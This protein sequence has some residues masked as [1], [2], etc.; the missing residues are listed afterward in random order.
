MKVTKVGFIAEVQSSPMLWTERKATFGAADMLRVLRCRDH[1][2]NEIITFEFPNTQSKQCL[3][4][5][6]VKWNNFC[7]ETRTVRYRNIQKGLKRLQEIIVDQGKRLLKL[8]DIFFYTSTPKKKNLSYNFTI[9]TRIELIL[10]KGKG[11]YSRLNITYM[12]YTPTRI[13]AVNIK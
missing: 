12:V 10:S 7:F 5:I 6:Q 3:V 2:I 8:P 11:L 1:S 4:E 13:G 9:S